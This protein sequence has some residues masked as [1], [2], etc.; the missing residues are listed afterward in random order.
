MTKGILQATGSVTVELV[1]DRT[2]DRCTC[3]N[4]SIHRIVDIGNIEQQP[5]RRAAERNGAACPPF[6]ELVG[7]HDPRIIDHELGV[8][9][10][11]AGVRQSKQLD[12]PKIFW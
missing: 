1:F 6:G 3:G 7:Q 2:H 10:L 9:D 4:R 12:G 8:P 5:H 11:P